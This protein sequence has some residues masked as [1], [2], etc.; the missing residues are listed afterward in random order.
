MTALYI[1][2]GIAAFFTL[3]ACLRLT[4]ILKAEEELFLF[5]KVLFIKVRLHPRKDKLRLRDYRIK[6]FRKRRKKEEK[7]Y[8]KNKIATKKADR[9]KEAKKKE[10]EASDAPKPSFRD[11][12]SYG[13]DV[14]KYVV[15]RALK[16]FGRHLR[17]DIRR[18]AV[19]VAEEDPAKT[20][21]TFGY[22]CQGVAYLKE[23]LERHLTLRY[24]K[25]EGVIAVHADYLSGQGRFEADISFH[26]RVWQVVAI[27]FSALKGYLS[28]PKR[29]G[30][31]PN[32]PK[33]ENQAPI[34]NTE[35]NTPAKAGKEVTSWQKT[36]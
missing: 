26:I 32:E 30:P 20:A 6:A 15:L 13:I 9:E 10:A 16:T 34:S 23:I 18:L 31:K 21:V 11:N 33:S 36:S 8:L 22:V 4:L 7:R 29:E 19:T 28:M 12:A 14:V 1:L 5:V 17:V 27:A 3:L 35:N 24:R 2:L 25:R